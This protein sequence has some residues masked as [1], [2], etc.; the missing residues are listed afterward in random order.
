MR[1][2]EKLVRNPFKEYQFYYMNEFLEILISYFP[3]LSLGITVIGWYAVSRYQ[4]R[5]FQSQIRIPRRVKG[6]EEF[7]DWLDQGFINEQAIV[8][9]SIMAE[10]TKGKERLH[11]IKRIEEANSKYL[12]WAFKDEFYI[13][14][15]RNIWSNEPEFS[16]RLSIFLKSL[17]QVF[18]LERRQY[19]NALKQGGIENWG[20]YLPREYQTAREAYYELLA[21]SEKLI[22]QLIEKEKR[23]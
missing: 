3:L 5:L 6:V 19:R 15:A 18:A 9:F 20:K 21:R 11:A 12:D 17:G 23:K 13:A 14:Y 1:S 22:D 10:D 2:L 8:T 16:N 7:I 4:K